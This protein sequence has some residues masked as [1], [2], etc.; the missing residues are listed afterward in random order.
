MSALENL[1]KKKTTNYLIYL[2]LLSLNNIHKDIRLIWIHSHVGIKGND[3]VDQLARDANKTTEENDVQ[4]AATGF[5]Y[6]V[7]YYTLAAKYA[8]GGPLAS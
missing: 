7:I 2:I 5:I 8:F 1:N 6:N 4:V 3:I